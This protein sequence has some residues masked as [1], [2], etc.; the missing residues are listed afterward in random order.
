[1]GF[2]FA[3]QPAGTDCSG[4]CQPGCVAFS[5][6]AYRR[7]DL[8]LVGCYNCR[9]SRAGSSLSLHA[10]GR[11]VDL[12]VHV[13]ASEQ[14]GTAE[15]TA[16]GWDIAKWCVT[17]AEPLGIQRV[18]WQSMEWDSRP[19]ERAWEP[20]GGPHHGN[21]IH[22]EFCWEAAKTLTAADFDAVDT[23]APTAQP[24]PPRRT[25]DS[26]TDASG[27]V[28][29]VMVGADNKVYKMT[30]VP[31]GL[32]STGLEALG[33]SAK[34]VS[35]TGDGTVVIAHGLDNCLYVTR[36]DG[37]GWTPWAKHSSAV[38]AG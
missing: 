33:G 3:Y 10:E 35:V 29:V 30:T 4:S 12:H 32:T 7:W 28:H 8:P 11:A 27:V 9:Q 26:T 18:I 15:Q 13:G 16:L 19:G 31:D 2:S 24:Q 14:D 17:N 25:V 36:W 37:S 1:M 21:H 34:A 20:Y 6:W 5:K 23:T 38:L 22:V